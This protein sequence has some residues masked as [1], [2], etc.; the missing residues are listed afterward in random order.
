M[1]QT[2]ANTIEPKPFK[3]G[4]LFA[5]SDIGTILAY[6]NEGGLYEYLIG[7]TDIGDF[8]GKTDTLDV[9]ELHSVSKQSINGRKDSTTVEIE[10]NASGTNLKRLEDKKNSKEF[11][12]VVGQTAIFKI[13]GSYSYDV[14]GVKANSP[15]KGKLTITMT[16][17]EMST[18]INLAEFEAETKKI[19]ENVKDF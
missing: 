16:S 19:I 8:G 14:S 7:V 15:L 13:N 6:K 9:T 17:K 12:I 10:F 11:A 3:V 5:D 18:T 2:V 4:D 1:G